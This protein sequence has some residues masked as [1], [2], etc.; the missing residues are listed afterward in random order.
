MKKLLIAVVVIAIL[1]GGAYFATKGDKDTNQNQANTQ[2]PATNQPSGSSNFSPVSTEGLDFVATV[3]TTTKAGTSTAKLEQDGSKTRYTIET[4]GQTSQFI[5]TKDT[6]YS[7][8]GGQCFKYPISQ[9]S[10]SGVDVKSYQYDKTQLDNLKKTAAYQGKK[11]C[12][13]GTCDVWS[14]TIAGATSTLYLDS[15]TQRISQV[16]T[17]IGA[18]KTKI[19]Y[20]YKNVSVTVPAN[21]KT[22]P[23]T[24]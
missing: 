18:N 20:E 17:A 3:T 13:A 5:Y 2:T 21:A 22:F 19:A 7:C 6:Y 10:S 9:S 24:P 11:D 16:E 14:V 12:P 4:S 8:S 23:T 1:G 15:N